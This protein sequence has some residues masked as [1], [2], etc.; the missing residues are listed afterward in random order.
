MKKNITI[1][2]LLAFLIYQF[3]LFNNFVWDDEEQILNNNLIHS[4]GNFPKFFSGGTFNSGGRQSL[5]GLYYKPLMTLFF[6]LIYSIFGSRPFFFH[7]ISLG[8][9]IA[10][11]ILVYA[12]FLY[13]FSDRLAFFLSLIFLVH[14]I[15]VEAVAYISSLQDLL[16]LFFGLTG[17]Y[18]T[19]KKKKPIWLSVFLLLSLLAKETGIV[20]FFIIPLYLF[21]FDKQL[22]KNKKS[23]L[24]F[25]A[26]IAGYSFLRFILAG[27]FFQKHNLS[28][29]NRMAFWERMI[30]LPKIIF[31]YLKNFFLPTDL[32]ISQH[33]VVR[34]YDWPNFY[35]P[36]IFDLLFFGGILFL[37][38]YFL[39]ERK[40]FSIFLFFFGWF[41]AGFSIHWHFFPL[42]MTVADRWFYF[43]VIGLL[44][45]IGVVLKNNFLSGRKKS[46]IFLFYAAI[47]S[48]F[49]FKSFLRTMDWKD[50]LTLYSHDI[51]INKDAFD[52]ENNLGVELFRV[53]RYQE[54]K[55]HFENSTKLA[56]YWWTN[57]NNL[58]VIY[59]REKN[60][61]KAAEFYQ[62]SI[63]NGDYYLAYENLAKILIFHSNDKEKAKSF[64]KKA[65][66]L[67]PE[68]QNLKLLDKYFQEQN[69]R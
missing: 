42:D 46:I 55:R 66:Q 37:F 56:P 53:E 31:Y 18:L 69:Q 12:I 24:Y 60:Y 34:F 43:P 13:F 28:P 15:N 23:L 27:I 33:W 40:N 44:G 2:I 7:L 30:S 8:F 16:F 26:P 65:L 36:L 9:H 57:W 38:R 67:F 68:N 10:N 54:A 11:T 25:L 59:E 49:S 6:S 17:F 5:S 20:F 41:L 47:I 1:I 19:I 62:K 21:L 22:L 4:L 52:L 58:G 61:Q 35:Q 51:N 45:M 14:P 3:S 63:I 48:L 64:L 32:A 39:K 29:I 50:G